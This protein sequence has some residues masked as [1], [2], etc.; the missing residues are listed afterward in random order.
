MAR[1]RWVECQFKSLATCPRSEDHLEKLLASLPQSL[2]ETYE[3]MLSKIDIASIEYARQILM[4]LCFA[5]RPLSV[6]EIIDGVVVE[7]GD[8]ARVNLKRRLHDEDDILQICPGF[9]DIETFPEYMLKEHGQGTMT[10]TLRIAHYSFQEHLE[11]DRIRQ[12]AGAI[13]SMQS[14]PSNLEGTQIWLVY[15]LGTVL[16]DAELTAAMLEKYPFAEYAA[17]YWY[18]HYKSSDEG[19]LPVDPVVLRFFEGENAAFQ[20]WIRMHDPDGAYSGIDFGR[21]AAPPV[22]YASLLGLRFV[23]HGLLDM[24]KE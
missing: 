18:E 23:V 19:V 8:N 7:L 6:R 17:R 9:I 14:C 2:D 24:K 16:S 15:L 3:R 13:F 11:S 20:N 1:F 12:Q 21:G 10:R 22:Y 5:K 4:W